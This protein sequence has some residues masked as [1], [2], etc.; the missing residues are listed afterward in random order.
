[1]IEEIEVLLIN[2]NNRYVGCKLDEVDRVI[3]D[4]SGKP[5][6][7]DALLPEDR[8]IFRLGDLLKIPGTIEYSSLLL[9]ERE[10]KKPIMIAIPAITDIL[11]LKTS[12][13]MVVPEYIRRKQD[14]LFVWGF[15]TD[16]KKWIMLITF[17]YF[18]VTKIKD[19]YYEL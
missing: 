13:I 8:D 7:V 9:L 2:M 17:T 4:I 5:G 11:K 6:D 3:T 14:P 19:G 1:M 10:L 18:N 15:F 12:R 16:K